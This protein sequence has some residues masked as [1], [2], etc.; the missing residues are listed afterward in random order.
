MPYGQAADAALGHIAQA[1]EVQHVVGALAEQR[2]F[3]T[4][5]GRADDRGEA[6]RL[7]AH[8][9]RHDEVLKHGKAA[10]QTDLLE[11]AAEAAHAR[12]ASGRMPVTSSPKS[13]TLPSVG[14][15]EAGHAVEQRGLA[16]AVRAE[17]ADN[18]AT[19]RSAA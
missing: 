3:T 9:L 14:R 16:G 18:L 19:G 1:H 12:G 10:D 17:D 2:L 13:R 11:R 5:G 4:S 8:V 15:I 6:R 7:D